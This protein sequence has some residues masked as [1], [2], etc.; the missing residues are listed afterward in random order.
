[1]TTSPSEAA[2]VTVHPLQEFADAVAE[3]VGGDAEIVFDT[4]KVTVSADEWADALQTARDELGLVFFSWLSTVDWAN[5]VSVGDPPGEEVEE[6]FEIL[7]T[8]ADVSE[9][10]RVTFSTELAK[11]SPSIDS[12]VEVYPGA[13]WHE[14]ESAEMFGISFEGHPNLEPLYLPEDFIGRPLRKDYPLLSREVKPWPG[15]VDVE[16]LPDE[17]SEENPEA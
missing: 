9:G 13:N 17:P 10:R 8:V 3:T 12:L 16:G 15:D 5:E 1:M 4:V 11:D 6:R 2:E 7:A 14:R